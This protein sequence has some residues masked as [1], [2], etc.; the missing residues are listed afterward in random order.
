MTAVLATVASWHNVA[1]P[2]GPTG[3][4]SLVM[5]TDVSDEAAE[6][7]RALRT[8]PYGAAFPGRAPRLGGVRGQQGR[9]R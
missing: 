6:A 2:A 1:A 8:L 3:S 9:R 7:I 4:S 5:S